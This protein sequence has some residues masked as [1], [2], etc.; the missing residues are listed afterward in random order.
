MQY[1]KIITQ[2][3]FIKGDYVFCSHHSGEFIQGNDEC[4]ELK[5]LISMRSFRGLIAT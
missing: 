5:V 3:V 4:L 1:F 2:Q